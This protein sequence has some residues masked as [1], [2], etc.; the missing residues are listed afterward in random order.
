MQI[1]QVHLLARHFEMRKRVFGR[2]GWFG[3]PL[4]SPPGASVVDEDLASNARCDGEKVDSIDKL[5][6]A[7]HE[8]EIDFV[9]ECS[10]LKGVRR[11]LAV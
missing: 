2:S 8:L 1:Q 6:L 3:G 11:T 7:V 4:L 10:G 5:S 9:D